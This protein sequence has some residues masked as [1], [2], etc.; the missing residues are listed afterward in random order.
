MRL[1]L[2]SFR[3]GDHP[4]HLVALAGGDRRRSVVIANAMDG[5]PPQVRRA[6]VELES[7]ALAG[8]GLGAAELDL[9]GY[10]GHQQR[11]RSGLPRTP[12][13]PSPS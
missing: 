1:Y 7:A 3:M 2:S 10:F 11:L 5:A 4:E 6:S 12:A 13:C 9:G 8:L